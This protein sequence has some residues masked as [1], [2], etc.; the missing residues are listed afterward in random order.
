MRCRPRSSTT[1]STAW[2]A[3]ACSS[4]S[5][6]VDGFAKFKD[7]LDDNI[8]EG[9]LS[10]PFQVFER[11]R[12]R[13]TER[14]TYARGLLKPGFDFTVKESYRSER[15]KLPWPKDATEQNELWRKRVKNDWLRLKLAGKEDGPIRET[16]DKRYRLFETRVK[17]LN[18]DDVF[19]TFLNAYAS[20]IEPH[21]NYLNPRTAENFNMSMRLSLEGIGAVLGRDDEY[22]VVRQIVKG[23][24]A[25]RRASSRSTTA[26]SAWRRATRAR[27]RT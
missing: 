10:P 18:G 19:Q 16:L 5:P 23:G 26:S 1:T 21:T 17:E 13:V 8:Y 24:P 20:A 14:T 3:S 7:K 15:S 12:Q 25:D 2:T 4:C 22:T 6:D 11:Y 9:D 27:P